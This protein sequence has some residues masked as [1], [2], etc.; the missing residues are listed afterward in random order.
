MIFVGQEFGSGSA[1]SSVS[2][3]LVWSR[4]MVAAVGSVD[5]EHLGTSQTSLSTGDISS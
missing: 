5:V 3:C 2:Q 4:L 1:E